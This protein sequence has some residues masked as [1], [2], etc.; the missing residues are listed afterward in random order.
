MSELI[1]TDDTRAFQRVIE[2]RATYYS[3]T[4]ENIALFPI[5]TSEQ[6]KEAFAKDGIFGYACTMVGFQP[7]FLKNYAN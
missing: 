2:L 6:C 1:K 3:M 5:N 7:H 4:G